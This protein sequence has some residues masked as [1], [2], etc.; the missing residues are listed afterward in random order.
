MPKSVMIF[1]RIFSKDYERSDHYRK[2]PF[3]FSAGFLVRIFSKILN[4]RT[5]DYTDYID[6][7][8]TTDFTDYTDKFLNAPFGKLREHREQLIN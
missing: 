1:C 6:F 5:V 3:L 2:L 7:Q 8:Q 4:F